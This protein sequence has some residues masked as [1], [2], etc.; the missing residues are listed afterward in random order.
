[1]FPILVSQWAESFLLRTIPHLGSVAPKDSTAEPQ[2][3]RNCVCC[4]QKYGEHGSNATPPFGCVIF[5]RY[6]KLGLFVSETEGT[7]IGVQIL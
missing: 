6:P 2:E 4:D 1:M 7:A 5:G 3:A